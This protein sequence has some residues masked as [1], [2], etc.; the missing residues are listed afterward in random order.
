MLVEQFQLGNAGP[1]TAESTPQPAA[2][3]GVLKHIPAP[4]EHLRKHLRW[5]VFAHLPAQDCL[6]PLP[7]FRAGS[8]QSQTHG[9]WRWTIFGQSGL[10]LHI[11]GIVRALQMQ[12]DF[13]QSDP[14]L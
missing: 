14:Q 2:R 10:L 6:Q 1:N 8:G 4:P 7:A 9:P 11:T 13:H 5:V 3:A 12:P